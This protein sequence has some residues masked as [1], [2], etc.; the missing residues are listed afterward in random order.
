[1][2]G[3]C[4]LGGHA[5]AAYPA[6]DIR[7]RLGRGDALWRRKNEKRPPSEEGGLCLSQKYKMKC[8]KN[9]KRRTDDLILP[10]V[11]AFFLCNQ[12]G[13][14]RRNATPAFLGIPFI[15]V[16][17]PAIHGMTIISGQGMI[18]SEFFLEGVMS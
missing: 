18:E 11:P 3:F 10:I 6:G 4:C 13:R 2:H 14:F 9:I 12:H 17:L 15:A 5:S 16:D 1:M 7:N 8:H